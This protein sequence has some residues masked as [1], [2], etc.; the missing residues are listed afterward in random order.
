MVLKQTIQEVIQDTIH[1]KTLDELAVGKSIP[2]RQVLEWVTKNEVSILK[3]VS[4]DPLS[5]VIHQKEYK[6]CF[7]GGNYCLDCSEQRSIFE[8]D[9]EE[10]AVLKNK[11]EVYQ[12]GEH[13][14]WHQIRKG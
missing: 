7:T 10:Y 12:G 6:L 14:K 13:S 3:T 8:D 11:I 4:I 5:K 2:R 9:K 1:I